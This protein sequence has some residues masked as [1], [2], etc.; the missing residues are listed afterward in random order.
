MSERATCW[1][2]T[3]NNPV[4]EDYQIPLPVGWKL[5][6]QLER[7]EQGTE[8]YQGMLRTAQVRFSAVKRVFPKAHIE[9]ARN[10]AALKKYVHK[11][12]TRIAETDSVPTM[13]EYQTIIAGKWEHEGYTKWSQ[14]FPNKTPDEV[15][16]LY[17][18]SLVA[19]DIEG[20]RRGAE[21]IAIN[22]MW[23][24]SWKIFWR[25]IIKRNEVSQARNASAGEGQQEDTPGVFEE[26]VIGSGES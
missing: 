26:A 9:V 14:S 1:S 3:I 17:L 11:E 12:D 13:F 6:G 22:P 2:I 23:R 21:F 10:P 20:G 4:I 18:D 7:G 16:L 8:H 19:T 5:E 24:S 25:S 15:A